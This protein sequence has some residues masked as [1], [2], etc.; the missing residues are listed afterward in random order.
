MTKV[1]MSDHEFVS[2]HRKIW[3]A[4][5][6]LR[7]IY[8]D[9]FKQLLRCVDGLHPIIEIG[10]GPGF[11]KEYF[12]HLISTDVVPTRYADV[13]CDACSLPFQ[14]GSVGAF[15][16]VDVLHHLPKPL[17]F[18]TEASRALQPGGRIAMIEP[19]I[20]VPSYLLYRY[21]HHEDCSLEVDLR[22]PFGELDKKAFDGNAAIPFKILKQFKEGLPSLR[23]VQVDPFLGLPYLA[24]MGFKSARPIPQALIK[25][26][27][28]CERLLSPLRRLA[29][30]RILIVW[31]HAFD[32]QINNRTAR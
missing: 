30:T 7:S 28:I 2:Q 22:C 8:Q 31:D 11:F 10:S 25:T 16:M 13:V 20:T 15:V 29:S 4:R 27:K 19:W 9:W 3:V 12:P 24:T 32:Q 1:A 23:L 17:E 5:P 14:S 21:F 18:L 26:A 6:E